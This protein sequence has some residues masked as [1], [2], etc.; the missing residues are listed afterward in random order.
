MGLSHTV[1]EINGDF[2]RKSQIFPTPVH[3]APPLKVLS[4]ELGTS[5]WIQKTRMI[6]LL[7]RG[8]SLTISPVFCIQCKNVTD[9]RTDRHRTTAKAALTHSVTR[10]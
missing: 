6:G 7:G 3:F 2:S 9:R 10:Q 5:A 4:L 1:C 8:R